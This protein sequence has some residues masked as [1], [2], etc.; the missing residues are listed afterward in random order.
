MACNIFDDESKTLEEKNA[1][2]S[3]IREQEVVRLKS[4][5]DFSTVE[6]IKNIPVP[7]VEVNG[8]SPTGRVEYYLRGQCFS[9]YYK[10][11]MLH[12]L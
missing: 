12:L 11:K 9:K 6:G 3:Q 7:C 1:S 5:Y 10:E 4:F 8:D 2:Y